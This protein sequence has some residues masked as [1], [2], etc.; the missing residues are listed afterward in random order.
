MSNLELPPTLIAA[1]RELITQA[2][3]QVSRSVNTLQVQTY[4]QIGRHIVEFEQD[5]EARAAYGKRLLAKLAEVLT[6]EFGKGFEAS[7]LRYVRLF[8]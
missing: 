7:N 4:W 5:D 2:R 6:A 8:Y 3:Q 1:L